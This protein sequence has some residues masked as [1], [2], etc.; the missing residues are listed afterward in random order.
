MELLYFSIKI[1]QEHPW[2]GPVVGTERRGMV[3]MLLLSFRSLDCWRCRLINKR[4]P[5]K[6]LS[7][8]MG[9]A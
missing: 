2:P 3:K 7:D 6:V 8:I 5:S 9:E 1:H 4:S